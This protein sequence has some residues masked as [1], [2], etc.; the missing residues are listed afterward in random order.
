MHGYRNPTHH[1]LDQAHFRFG[2]CEGEQTLPC[3]PCDNAFRFC[4]G[5]GRTPGIC[6]VGLAESQLIAED[7]DDLTFSAGKKIGGLENPLMFS[8]DMW[9]VSHTLVHCMNDSV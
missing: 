8:G 4:I 2:C 1:S 5:T 7:D 9:P 3:S 6:D